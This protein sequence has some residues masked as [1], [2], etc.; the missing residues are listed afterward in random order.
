MTDMIIGLVLFLA[1]LVLIIL[2][3]TRTA[4]KLQLGSTDV[5]IALVPVVLWLFLSGRIGKF[6]IAGV[7]V[8]AAIRTAGKEELGKQVSEV[9]TPLPFT[10]TGVGA[11]SD[12]WGI[13]DGAERK[14]QALSFIQGDDYDGHAIKMYLDGIPTLRYLTVNRPDGTLLGIAD[15]RAVGRTADPAEIANRIHS[16]D[17]AVLE[18]LPGYVPA[19]AAVKPGSAKQSTLK[20]MDSLN[21][22]TLPVVDDAGKFI[23][24]VD[25]SKLTASILLE[26]GQKLDL[27]K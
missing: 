5:L 11:K 12:M 1:P 6:G 23:G 10:T 16:S 4:A 17:K 7:T 3:R 15:A 19:T 9:P 25:R 20:L 26:I 18:G 22:E 24:I 8:E 27:N 13:R 21:L 14:I 2:I